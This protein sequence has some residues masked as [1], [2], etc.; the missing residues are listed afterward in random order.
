[1]KT[2]S[3]PFQSRISVL[4][5]CVLILVSSHATADV[6]RAITNAQAGLDKAL[7]TEFPTEKKHVRFEKR[8]DG[9]LVY[10]V[11][12]RRVDERTI[13]IRVTGYDG[14][15]EAMLSTFRLIDQGNY[16]TI[17]EFRKSKQAASTDKG[18]LQKK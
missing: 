6:H 12:M 18:S 17:E 7:N 4:C 5:V 10:K 1:M 9:I 14:L 13:K 15:D 8:D 11:S 2:Q 16:K 3:A